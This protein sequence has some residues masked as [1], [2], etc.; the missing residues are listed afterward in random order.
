MEIKNS[1]LCAVGRHSYHHCL[2]LHL[3]S[4]SVLFTLTV[5]WAKW[6]ISSFLD[7]NLKMWAIWFYVLLLFIGLVWPFSNVL[8]HVTFCYCVYLVIIVNTLSLL[9]NIFIYCHRRI[10]AIE[11][12]Q[13]G[14]YN[15]FGLLIIHKISINP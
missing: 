5:I 3:V 4:G 14:G 1:I 12:L 11:M 7:T 15:Y 13:S 2:L 8:I 9:D 10:S 6:T